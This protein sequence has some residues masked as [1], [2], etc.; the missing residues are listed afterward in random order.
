MT[1]TVRF[2]KHKSLLLNFDP[3]EVECLLDKQIH[4]GDNLIFKEKVYKVMR[5]SKTKLNKLE[6]KRK[7]SGKK[8]PI[9][10]ILKKT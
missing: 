10:S 6:L 7:S 1:K 3:S 9:K 2:N 5:K 8:I 4:V